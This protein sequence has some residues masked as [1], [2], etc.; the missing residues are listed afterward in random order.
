MKMRRD[1]NTPSRTDARDGIVRARTHGPVP[2]YRIP[3]LPHGRY[4]PVTADGKSGGVSAIPRRTHDGPPPNTTRNKQMKLIEIK[5][6]LDQ[7]QVQYESTYRSDSP[8]FPRFFLCRH[9]LEE[10]FHLPLVREIWVSLH[11]KLRPISQ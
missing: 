3:V 10:N 7:D 8:W 1:L 6:I 2:R 11:N 4:R 9:G 5:L